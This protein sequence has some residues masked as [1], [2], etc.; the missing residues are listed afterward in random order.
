MTFRALAVV[1]I[2]V[3]TGCGRD[4]PGLTGVIKADGSS[5]VHPL[6]AAVAESFVKQHPE[7]QVS[8]AISGTSAGFQQFCRGEADV[9]NASRPINAGERAACAASGIDFVE[10]PVAYDALTL[11]VHPANDW[12]STITVDELKRLWEPAAEGRVMRWSDVRAGWPDQ[13]IQLFGPGQSSGTFDYFTEAVTG[14]SRASR[15]DYTASEDDTVT[16]KGVAD[17]RYALG[18]VGYSYFHQNE[19]TLKAVPLAGPEAV[20]LGAVLPSIDT[21]QRG[22]YRPLSRTLF[23]YVNAASL[24]RPA[25][26]EFVTFYLKQ[27]QG[28]VREVGGIPMTLRTYELVQQRVAKKITG[29]LFPEGQGSQ[30]LE[31]VL[32]RAQ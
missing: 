16:V 19:K 13:P 21:V 22:T 28:L 1:V 32:T 5:T 25:L 30:S 3:M 4:A 15:K 14:T 6:T 9:Q 31:L 2:V 24:E 11:I 10:I 18:Y 17:N 8:V 27:D 29:T 26:A 23:I 12:A 7:V 20:R